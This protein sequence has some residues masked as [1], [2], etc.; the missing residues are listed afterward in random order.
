MRYFHKLTLLIATAWILSGC[1]IFNKIEHPQPTSGVDHELMLIGTLGQTEKSG[2]IQSYSINPETLRA[3]HTGKV[4]TPSPTYM[5]LNRR[6]SVLYVTNET[7][8]QPTVSAYELNKISGELTLLNQSYTLGNAPTYVSVLDDKV[9]TANYGSGSITLFNTDKKGFLE[10]ADWRIDLTS[11][12][13][14]HPHAVVIT[15]NGK[16]LFVPDL[17]QDKVFHFNTS[18]TNPPLTIDTEHTDLPKGTGP[19]H[20]IFD[21]TGRYAYLIAEKSPRIYVYKHHNGKLSL[22]QTI[23]TGAHST[24]AHISLSHS[25]KHLYASFRSGTPGIL[26]YGVEADGKLSEVGFCP[27]GAHPRQFAISPTDDYIAVAARDSNE[28]QV[29]IR[30]KKSGKLTRSQLTILVQKPVF[31]LWD[32]F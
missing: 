9:L 27:T 7:T 14:S 20:L 21:G 24:G 15:P 4:L 18:R 6:N 26:I 29:F 30:D 11:A 32:R 13:T 23:D 12:G 2:T 22:I 16:G 17:A 31:I 25:G 28:V 10:Q 3:E 8:D 19:R 1:G 5:A